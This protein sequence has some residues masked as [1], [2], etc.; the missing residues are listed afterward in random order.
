MKNDLKKKSDQYCLLINKYIK[1]KLNYRINYNIIALMA[2]KRKAKASAEVIPVE[3]ECFE[4]S[5]EEEAPV[6]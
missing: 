3:T 4:S 6:P 5:E 1:F 2:K